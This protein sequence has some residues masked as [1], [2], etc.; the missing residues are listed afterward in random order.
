MFG[1]L[2]SY[3]PPSPPPVVVLNE[4]LTAV[5]GAVLRVKGTAE[6]AAEEVIE[7]GV[8]VRPNENPPAVVLAAV[9][10]VAA[11]RNREEMYRT[12]VK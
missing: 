4:A 1:Q 9:L 5:T 3:I 7:A 6:N 10:V 8:E 12:A 11:T 2:P